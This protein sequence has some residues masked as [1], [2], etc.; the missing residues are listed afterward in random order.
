MIPVPHPSARS[1]AEGGVVDLDLFRQGS[2]CEAL[3]VGETCLNELTISVFCD[4]SDG[5]LMEPDCAPP[6]PVFMLIP[7]TLIV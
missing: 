3:Q 5:L 2:Y 6:D 7:V 1:W 4:E